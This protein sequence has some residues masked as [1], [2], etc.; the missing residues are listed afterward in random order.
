[1]QF[2]A[3]TP[4]RALLSV[5]KGWWLCGNYFWKRRGELLDKSLAPDGGIALSS[6]ADFT[7]EARKTKNRFPENVMQI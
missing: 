3:D 7:F 5:V 4:G 6:N 2:S 1:M